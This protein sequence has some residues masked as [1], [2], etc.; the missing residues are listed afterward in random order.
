[1]RRETLARHIEVIWSAGPPTRRCRGPRGS[2]RPRGGRGGASGLGAGPRG[3]GWWPRGTGRTRGAPRGGPR[4]VAPRKGGPVLELRHQDTSTDACLDLVDF[5]PFNVLAIGRPFHL[6][7]RA[8]RGRRRAPARSK[9]RRRSARRRGSLLGAEP[10]PTPEDRQM[11][12]EI[13][14]VPAVSGNSPRSAPAAR[15]RDPAGLLSKHTTP[16]PP[17]GMWRSASRRRNVAGQGFAA[18]APLQHRGTGGGRRDAPSS[19]SL[20]LLTT[21]V[22]HAEAAGAVVEEDDAH[23]ERRGRGAER[24]AAPQPASRLCIQRAARGPPAAIGRCTGAMAVEREGDRRAGVA[25]LREA[26]GEAAEHLRSPSLEIPP[27]SKVKWARAG[28]DYW[29]GAT[30]K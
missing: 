5:P 9:G 22:P 16:Q 18:G 10:F 24:E 6:E 14:G 23:R 17:R 2:G 15:L 21:P 7:G 11:L 25:A 28:S 26:A 30:R 19:C 3:R 8:F 20:H 1:M 29:L 27:P 13:P 12:P 4:D